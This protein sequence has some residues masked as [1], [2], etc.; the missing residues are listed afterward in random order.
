M[1]IATSTTLET[2]I[3]TKIKTVHEVSW[4]TEI[5]TSTTTVN[6]SSESLSTT[7]SSA[8]PTCSLDQHCD[9]STSRLDTNKC[10]VTTECQTVCIHDHPDILP[11]YGVCALSNN[12][13]GLGPQCINRQRVNDWN[14]DEEYAQ[15][16]ERC[17]CEVCEKDDGSFE[18]CDDEKRGLKSWPVDSKYRIAAWPADRP[19]PMKPSS[20]IKSTISA[21][22]TPAP[23]PP[24][25]PSTTPPPPPPPPPRSSVASSEPST[26]ASTYCPAGPFPGGAA[27]C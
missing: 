2:R 7:T 22:S 19:W 21:Q 4:E 18:W 26:S 25:P 17:R 11:C 23:A 14:T 13:K 24:S 15:C 8:G 10:W 20:S 5:T 12:T 1:E 9:A 27:M 3:R 6:P 16:C